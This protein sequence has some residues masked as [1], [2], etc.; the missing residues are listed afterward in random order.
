[1]RKK[2]LG[3][4][5]YIQFLLSFMVV[6]TILLPAL[7][8]LCAD[9]GLGGLVSATTPNALYESDLDGAVVSLKLSDNQF[10][11]GLST[12]GF[13]L[14]NA[15]LGL[16]I[17]S[18]KRI[19]SENADI[20][21]AFNHKDF[22]ENIENFS[23]KILKESL[24]VSSYDLVAEPMVIQAVIE[25]SLNLSAS[26]TPSNLSAENLD[27]ASIDLILDNC[28]F[29]NPYSI[30]DYILNNA[31]PGTMIG[32]I[33]FVD[34]RH[35]IIKLKYTGPPEA[36]ILS[37]FNITAIVDAGIEEVAVKSS[38]LYISDTAESVPYA[39]TYSDLSRSYPVKIDTIGFN[40]RSGIL[41]L[42]IDFKTF[43][44][45]ASWQKPVFNYFI[46]IYDGT[47]TL[48]GTYGSYDAPKSTPVSSVYSVVRTKNIQ[49]TVNT[50]LDKAYKIKVYVKNVV[51]Y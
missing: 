27:G 35:V 8:C 4:F 1:M 51:F 44:Y 28:N 13:E 9:S 21:L 30:D 19:D 43:L 36:E 50:P 25:K 40:S 34:Y 29:K 48:I 2:D 49:V 10:A 11:S 7:T 45:Y 41:Y 32:S 23:I 24:I 37:D 22:D 46:E 17:A 16:S 39:L 47:G 14:I 20:V 31:P 3:L 5:S 42:N 15:P 26:P 6:I 38:L 33:E 12:G 18:V